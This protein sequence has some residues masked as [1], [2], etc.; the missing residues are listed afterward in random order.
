[1]LLEGGIKVEMNFWIEYLA[2]VI[3]LMSLVVI[4]AAILRKAK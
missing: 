3:F 2:T 4:A 1:M